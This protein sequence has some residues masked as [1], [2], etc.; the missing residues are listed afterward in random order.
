MLLLTSL[1]R[2][3]IVAPPPPRL[4]IYYPTYPL[5]HRTVGK[6]N[7][8]GVAFS[9]AGIAEVSWETGGG[10]SGPAVLA[11]DASSVYCGWE[12][13]VLALA[14][15]S[16]VVTIRAR[17]ASGAQ[18]RSDITIESR[19]FPINHRVD[20]SRPTSG[21]GSVALP[22]NTLQ[23]AVDA[24]YSGD[25]IQINGGV[26]N[27]YLPYGITHGLT[28]QGDPE[29]PPAVLKIEGGHIATVTPD[30]VSFKH[31]RMSRPHAY[32]P[33]F[34]PMFI[35]GFYPIPR[36]VGARTL[37]ED[38]QGATLYGES[39]PSY[40]VRR[41]HD[42]LIHPSSGG[43][44]IYADIEDS[45]GVRLSGFPYGGVVDIRI[46]N[47]EVTEFQLDNHGRFSIDI[48]RSLIRSGQLL[49]AQNYVNT[50]ELQL[51]LRDSIVEATALQVNRLV[52]PCHGLCELTAASLDV[53]IERNEF[54]DSHIGLDLRN[55]AMR[56]RPGSQRLLVQNNIMVRSGVALELSQ[57]DATVGGVTQ[58][59]IR[60][61]TFIGAPV[62][63][64][65]TAAMLRSAP[66]DWSLEIANNIIAGSGTAISVVSPQGLVAAHILGNDLHGNGVDIE[67]DG[68][69]VVEGNIGDDPRFRERLTGDYR[70][71]SDSPCIDA[72]LDIASPPSD[73]AAGSVRPLDGDGDGAG[74][75]DIGAFE[76]PARPQALHMPRRSL[77][78]IR[79]S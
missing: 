29:S 39:L 35:S 18:L 36:P 49:L 19:G 64:G 7:V 22:F 65:T 11:C 62:A 10:D 27:G 40:S 42:V 16:T 41:C 70:L 47:S 77:K 51:T 28:I 5:P 76:S 45:T 25:T 66:P 67:H 13:G 54:T 33:G 55:T 31:L 53:I 73:D 38:V 59:L 3:A 8:V 52:H 72:A 69:A 12:T 75:A 71:R 37:L 26:C 60:H 14:P 15:G 48:E 17:D 57:R 34:Q 9:S 63:V 79:G 50:D 32:S 78:R 58:A 1:L 6:V 4:D 68:T 23:E 43:T 61:N 20:C 24:S 74:R 21:D 46:R 30:L 56:E 2:L 44:S